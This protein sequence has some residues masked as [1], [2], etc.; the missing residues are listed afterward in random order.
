MVISHTKKYGMTLI[1][2]SSSEQYYLSHNEQARHPAHNEIPLKVFR[3]FCKVSAIPLVQHSNIPTTHCV[4]TF[5]PLR[6]QRSLLYLALQQNH[7]SLY[8]RGDFG[9][10]IKTTENGTLVF[11]RSKMFVDFDTKKTWHF[12]NHMPI[13]KKT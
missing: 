3:A 11:H 7:C 12:F 13:E 8:R 2:Y 5:V 6:M 10:N 9:T 4:P 1:F